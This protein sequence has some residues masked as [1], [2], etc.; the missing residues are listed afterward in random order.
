[1]FRISN[2]LHSLRNLMSDFVEESSGNDPHTT[3]RS[4][5]WELLHL[6]LPRFLRITV[7]NRSTSLEKVI[8]RLQEA[9]PAVLLMQVP[10]LPS[11]V[12]IPGYVSI[13]L[14]VLAM[15][16]EGV[17]VFPM[18]IASGIPPEILAGRGRESP[19]PQKVLDLCCCPGG[20]FLMLSDFLA[21]DATIVGVDVSKQRMFTTKSLV[22][23]YLNAV[24][25][26]NSCHFTPPRMLLFSSDGTTFARDSSEDLLYDSR[27]GLEE[28][29]SGGYK[30]KRNKSLR[31]REERR[32]KGVRRALAAARPDEVMTAAAVAA[33]GVAKRDTPTCSEKPDEDPPGPQSSLMDAEEGAEDDVFDK[34]DA[35]L[36]DA[37]C[38]HDS[39][40]RHM[41]YV[42]DSNST[43]GNSNIVVGDSE[44][45]WVNECRNYKNI[46]SV[47]SDDS[48]Y[49]LQ[50]KLLAKGFASLVEG[51]ELVYSTCSAE[52]AQNESVVQ[53]LLEREQGS[54]ELVP[55]AEAWCREGSGAGEG[56][57]GCGGGEGGE[58]RGLLARQPLNL[59][60]LR[61]FLAAPAPAPCAAAAAAPLSAFS[62]CQA[63]TN[64]HINTQT[65]IETETGIE[66]GTGTGSPRLRRLADEMC[67]Y[68]AGLRAPPGRPGALAGTAYFGLWAG[69]SG[70]FLSRMR[71]GKGGGGGEVCCVMMSE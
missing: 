30:R 54:V 33:G 42:G 53:W 65:E 36:V 66:T 28:I 69:T 70:L 60:A 46:D 15:E 47:E 40:Y 16:E 48:V 59:S 11:F 67:R 7:K 31:G 32:L 19:P 39:S 27:V 52:V 20:K 5:V 61:S 57:G 50:K 17:N 23:K 41:R 4:D 68:S 13:S 26:N 44:T 56:S 9:N 63:Q 45:V 71:R 38:T 6:V 43:S 12:A 3:S 10:W 55:V 64:I 2:C 49:A 25:A 18:D 62:S 14:L 1:M 34:Y 24:Y 37:Q 58:L 29:R 8:Q 22:H 21:P 51:G 35:V